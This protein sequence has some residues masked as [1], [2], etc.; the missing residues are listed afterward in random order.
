MNHCF[1]C[2]LTACKIASLIHCMCHPQ[3]GEKDVLVHMEDFLLAEIDI[4]HVMII[5][6]IY[7]F[8]FIS[9][10]NSDLFTCYYVIAYYRFSSKSQMGEC[11]DHRQVF[12][13]IQEGSNPD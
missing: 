1:V 13:G 2:W 11:N 7:I 12:L 3:D 9:N 10:Q 8:I 4:I 5:M 6:I